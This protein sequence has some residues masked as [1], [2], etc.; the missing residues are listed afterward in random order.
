MG[1]SVTVS[2]EDKM[3]SRQ[4]YTAR[5]SI[6]EKSR[7]SMLQEEPLGRSVPVT[8]IPSTEDT[9][10]EPQLGVEIVKS[11]YELYAEK[12]KWIFGLSIGLLVSTFANGI[13]QMVMTQWVTGSLI[14]LFA[15]IA[16]LIVPIIFNRD[17]FQK[18]ARKEKK[19]EMRNRFESLASVDY[20]QNQY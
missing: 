3:S 4:S 12:V 17:C 6:I 18:L 9:G 13:A 11:E 20:H 8:R 10:D 2:S 19:P 5:R 15:I 16:S 7:K 1:V 14:L